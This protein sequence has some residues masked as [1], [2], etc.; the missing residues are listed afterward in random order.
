MDD[1]VQDDIEQGSVVEVSQEAV[2]A[3]PG[4]FSDNVQGIHNALQELQSELG[5]FLTQHLTRI[6]SLRQQVQNP[7]S[8]GDVT[9]KLP[10]KAHAVDEVD[11]KAT[12]GLPSGGNVS[13]WIEHDSRATQLEHTRSSNASSV[14][15]PPPPAAVLSPQIDAHMRHMQQ[16]L[17]THMDNVHALQK[18]LGQ[19]HVTVIAPKDSVKQ[20]GVNSGTSFAGEWD[21]LSQHFSLSVL[22]STFAGALIV[23]FL[24]LVRLINISNQ[25][26]TTF[27]FGMLFAFWALATHL[28]NIFVAGRGA[29]ICIA[30][31]RVGRQ[32]QPPNPAD[33][34]QYLSLSEQLQFAATLLFIL[35]VAVLSFI[36]FTN[37]GFPLVFLIFS[38]LAALVVFGSVYWRVE[39]SLGGLGFIFRHRRWRPSSGLT[40]SWGSR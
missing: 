28:L 34:G 3:H 6:T 16:F 38:L 27:S 17:Q 7:T 9:P 15:Y 23:V 25:H 12:A 11:Q 19:P 22:A 40:H 33:I 39:L 36:V 26:R 20:R 29:A 21:A 8:D 4:P 18:S 30:P 32:Q 24:S 31:L 37:L 35:P 14:L 2:D 1:S 13:S 5:D 10:H